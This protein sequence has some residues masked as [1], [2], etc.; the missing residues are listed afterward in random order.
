MAIESSCD[1]TSVSIL[2]DGIPLSNVVSSQMV[3]E[4]YGGVVPEMASREHQKNIVHVAQ[5]ALNQANVK[6]RSN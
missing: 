2:K 6:K 3:H 4:N 1:D 5:F